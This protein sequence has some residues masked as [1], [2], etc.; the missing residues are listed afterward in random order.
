MIHCG[1]TH[2]GTN[3]RCELMPEQKTTGTAARMTTIKLLYY[4]NRTLK[5]NNIN[6][7]NNK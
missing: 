5:N 6:N 7:D 3:T 1:G 2:I 4:Y